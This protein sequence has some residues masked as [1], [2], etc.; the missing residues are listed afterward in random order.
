MTLAP[1]LHTDPYYIRYTQTR[2]RG[3]AE[4]VSLKAKTPRGI[5]CPPRATQ[6]FARIV[7]G[8]DEARTEHDDVA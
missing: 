8:R 5:I 1:L 6:H 2:I 4:N 3:S 7:Q